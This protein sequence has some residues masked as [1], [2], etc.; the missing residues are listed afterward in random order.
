MSEAKLS[1]DQEWAG[2]FEREA[3]V[4]LLSHGAP[5]LSSPTYA[6]QTSGVGQAGAST[7]PNRALE[8]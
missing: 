7:A 1:R 3:V 4:R 8:I 6:A 2:I 5:T